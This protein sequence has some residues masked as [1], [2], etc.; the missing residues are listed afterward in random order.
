MHL[1]DE[2]DDRGL[3]ESYPLLWG[4]LVT[5][6]ALDKEGRKCKK[7]DDAFGA[8]ICLLLLTMTKTQRLKVAGGAREGAWTYEL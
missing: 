4:G 6:D 7:E 5:A 1:S 8:A 3:K 2:T